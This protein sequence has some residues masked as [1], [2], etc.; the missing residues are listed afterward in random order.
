MACEEGGVNRD[1]TL[2][3]ASQHM[4]DHGTPGPVVRAIVEDLTAGDYEVMKRADYL[5]LRAEPDAVTK[6]WREE[7]IIRQNDREK[8]DR[9]IRMKLEQIEKA[10]AT[11]HAEVVGAS[12]AV[13]KK[14]GERQSRLRRAYL[15]DALS[16]LDGA[17]G[18][19]REMTAPMNMVAAEPQR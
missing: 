16:T 3:H 15:K 17:M 5:H 12:K 14:G 1:S 9:R 13:P 2:L 6:L 4:L 10:I 7:A 11:A 18:I 19:V 8:S